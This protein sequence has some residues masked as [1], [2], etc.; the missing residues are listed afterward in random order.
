MTAV[1]GDIACA[2]LRCIVS[3][4][5]YTKI[6]GCDITEYVQGRM[7][8]DEF[9]LAPPYKDVDAYMDFV[10]KICVEKNI[11]HFLPMTE[12]EIIIANQNRDFFLEK[13]IKLMIN[14]ELIINTATSKYKTAKFLAERGICVPKTYTLDNY[15]G[16]LC[17]P[18]I[19]K[20]DGGCGSKNLHLVN[21]KEEFEAAILQSET[22]VIQE[23][24]GNRD[25]E[26]TVGIFSDGHNI[27]SIAFRRRLGYGGMS[28][29]V[30]TIDDPV[31]DRIAEQ[32][33]QGLQ[34]RGSIN[35]QLRKTSEDYYIFEINPRIS[36]TVGFR[37][38]FGFHDVTWWLNLLDGIENNL[39]YHTI[40]GMKGIKT[41]DEMIFQ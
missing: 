7:Y 21:N 16:Q 15:N 31:L 19:I 25:E 35:I 17:Y 29:Y 20:P 24:I 13:D 11:T 5:A 37:D 36:S 23:Y 4:K 38:K 30:E 14:N 3:N 10:R 40:G 9:V 32:V 28:I 12:P 22:F 26:Y 18:L 41:L 1:G 27:R 2:T 8:I 34:L 39:D 6:I 33:A